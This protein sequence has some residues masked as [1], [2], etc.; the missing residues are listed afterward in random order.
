[1]ELGPGILGSVLDGIGRPLD[2]MGDEGDIFLRKGFEAPTVPRDRKW[3]FIP[4]MERGQKYFPGDIYGVM[5]DVGGLN[6][7]L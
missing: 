6:I 5:L 7:I 3:K 4:L 2:R 1:M